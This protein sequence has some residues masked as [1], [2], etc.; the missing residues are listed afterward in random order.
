MFHIISLFVNKKSFKISPYRKSLT[1]LIEKRRLQCPIE[2]LRPYVNIKKKE[3]KG[4][5][6]N[7][8][9]KFPF[10]CFF[11]HT[12][13]EWGEWLIYNS[14]TL[15]IFVKYR[16]FHIVIDNVPSSNNYKSI[17]ERERGT[18]NLSD[19]SPTAT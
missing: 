6:S 3:L 10:K 9:K 12:H 2:L 8:D 14:L 17:E 11:F 18:H 19:C 16:I 1:F 4:I 7:N 15:K 5:V 13:V